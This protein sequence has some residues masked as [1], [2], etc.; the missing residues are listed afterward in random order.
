MGGQVDYRE[1]Y[2]EGLE[3]LRGIGQEDEELNLE[4]LVQVGGDIDKATDWLCGE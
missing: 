1:M 2:K 4:V 3:F